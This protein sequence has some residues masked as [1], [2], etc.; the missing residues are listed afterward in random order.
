[1]VYAILELPVVM[2]GDFRQV[3]PVIP[4]GSRANIVDVV[5]SSS[6][7]L[8]SVKVLHLTENMCLKADGLTDDSRAELAEFL[9][10][11]CPVGNGTVQGIQSPPG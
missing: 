10:W 4:G 2:G 9:E 6:A 11:V 7:L 8:S 3:F 1:L 5:L